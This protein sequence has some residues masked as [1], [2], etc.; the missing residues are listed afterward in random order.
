MADTFSL[1]TYP[2]PRAQAGPS[3]LYYP[4]IHFRSRRWLRM[5]LLYYEDI[6]RIVPPGFEPETAEAYAGDFVD[7]DGLLDDVRELRALGFIRDEPPGNA[8]PSVADEFFDFYSSNLTDPLKR[9]TLIPALSR[10]REYLIHPDKMDPALLELLR[11]ADVARQQAGDPYSDWRLEP[12]VAAFYM[13]FLA[14]HMA[15]DRPLIS[16]NSLYQSL[17]F[18]RPAGESSWNAQDGRFRLATAVIDSVIPGDLENVPLDRLLRL[19]TESFE[20]RRR[21]QDRMADFGKEIASAASEEEFRDT[22]DRLGRKVRDEVETTRDRIESLNITTATAL[23]GLS[24]PSWA[25]ATWGLALSAPVVIAGFGAVALSA[26]LLRYRF[27]NRIARRNPYNFLLDLSDL[28]NAET[29][30]ENIV[31]LDRLDPGDDDDSRIHLVY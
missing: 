17:L 12:V 19:R 4:H 9:T 15:G 30:A 2:L 5:A 26:A 8:L 31:T 11:Q 7:A 18:R 14:S 29:L 6:S 25:T 22:V 20:D 3:A 16:D 21:F 13:L 23:I 10:H 24:I 27:E 1:T 28:V